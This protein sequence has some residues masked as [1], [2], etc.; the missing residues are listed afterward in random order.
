MEDGK[1]II[2]QYLVAGKP[3]EEVKIEANGCLVTSEFLN[4]LSADK[5][6]SLI[7]YISAAHS[8]VEIKG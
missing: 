6:E 5:W 7:E 4:S 1:K 3:I 8:P 2:A